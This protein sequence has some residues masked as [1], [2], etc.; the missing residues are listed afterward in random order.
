MKIIF[1]LGLIIFEF[2]AF[3]YDVY[4]SNTNRI[5]I[6]VVIAGNGI[7]K[8]VVANVG[9]VVSVNSNKVSNKIDVYSDGVLNIP[10]VAV[11]SSVYTNVQVSITNVIS[12]ESYTMQSQ[13]QYAFLT[14]WKNYITNAYSRNF[15]AT[16]TCAGTIAYTHTALGKPYTFYTSDTTFPHP[17]LSTY[18]SAYVSQ[19]DKLTSSLPGC[20]TF[21]AIT[22]TASYY[23][24]VTLAPWGFMGGTSYNGATSYKST[25]QEFNSN[26][27]LPINVKAGDSGVI[28]TVMIYG[29]VNFKKDGYVQGRQEI[30]YQVLPDTDSNVIINT[31]TMVYDGSNALTL[32][33]QSK[34][35]LD[36]N[37]SYVFYEI[38]QQYFDGSGNYL[39]AN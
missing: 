8:N 18:Q 10:V 38:E 5:I 25:L 13:K 28:G 11:G 29:T 26:V 1:L 24:A 33:D 22:T 7:Y 6:P 14:A 19:L 32:I 9:N 36:N 23:D 15:V 27:I 39:K 17:Q 37:N 3:A 21:S 30:S 16:G 31:I 4:D 2:N 20:S 34:Y 12:I 35:K